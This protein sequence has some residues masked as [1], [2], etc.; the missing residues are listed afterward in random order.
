MK[1][2]RAAIRRLL[3]YW[4]NAER[5]RREKAE[6]IAEIDQ[7]IAGLYD[8]SPQRLTGMPHVARMGDPTADAAARN[9]KKLA[10]LEANK[11]RLADEIAELDRRTSLIE[12]EVMCLPPLESEVIRLRYVRYGVAKSGYWQ[13]IARRVHVSESHAK[14]LESKGV[15]RLCTTMKV[16]TIGYDL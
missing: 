5:A 4:G 12:Y 2:E 14:K 10:G 16:D 9:A 13:K 6:R 11:A 8:L 7:E 3:M 15:D 1:T